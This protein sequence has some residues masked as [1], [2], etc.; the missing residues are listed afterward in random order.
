LE[1]AFSRAILCF[2]H[3]ALSHFGVLL[4]DWGVGCIIYESMT[5]ISPFY[6]EGMDQIM[7]F[8]A[9]ASGDFNFPRK[10]MSNESKMIIRDFLEVDPSNRLGSLAGGLK[11][12]YR[13]PWF[14]DV[15]WVKL[16]KQQI[17]APWVPEIKDPLSNANFR[18]WSKMPDKEKVKVPAISPE[19]QA[20][21]ETF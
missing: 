6:V 11:D 12:I 14:H 21:F 13:H 20:L 16:R 19:E 4:T 2:T 10:P 7:L 1:R 8:K 17:T 5:G 9:I 3:S 18:D 15:D